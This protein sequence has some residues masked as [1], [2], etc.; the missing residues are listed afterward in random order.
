MSLSH[1]HT[2]T[3]SRTHILSQT[4]T[5]TRAHILT[6]PYSINKQTHT[7]ARYVLHLFGT[8]TLVLSIGSG[9]ILNKCSH[10]DP[11]KE[12]FH[13]LFY[14]AIVLCLSSLPVTSLCVL[15]VYF[16][17][18]LFWGSKGIHKVLIPLLYKLS[19]MASCH[20]G[21]RRAGVCVCMC[22]LVCV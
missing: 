11:S 18:K 2:H 8:Q 14:I 17:L 16:S 6:N 13:P 4:C 9:Y 5:Q 7:K 22:A 20:Y 3:Y 19:S 1:T 12:S 10:P 15:S 21:L